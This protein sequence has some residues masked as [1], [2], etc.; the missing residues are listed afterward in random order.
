MKVSRN[1]FLAVFTLFTLTSATAT[2]DP[3]TSAT[4]EIKSMLQTTMADLAYETN[5]T[6]HVTF[7]I[8]ADNK[9]VV[10]ST[11]NEELDGVIKASLNYKALAAQTLKQETKYTV[12]VTFK[13]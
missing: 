11:N 9:I 10:L 13:S 4:A 5:T 3:T 2:T 6:V 12:P 7:M 8:T 1:I